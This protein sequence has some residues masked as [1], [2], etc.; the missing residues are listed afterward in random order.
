MTEI[1]TDEACRA[2]IERGINRSLN[3]VIG[4]WIPFAGEPSLREVLEHA[5]GWL[6][7]ITRLEERFRF[8][9]ERW[10][11]ENSR[12][13]KQY[14]KELADRTRLQSEI[15]QLQ[16]ELAQALNIRGLVS[17]VGLSKEMYKYLEELAS[18]YPGKVI[19]APPEALEFPTQSINRLLD[20]FQAM[21]HYMT[22]HHISDAHRSIK[23]GQ[24]W[25]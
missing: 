15:N 2:Q 11:D 6:S 5:L 12:L 9:R 20:H 3:S 22:T 18:T 10:M 7:T 8:H 25:H 21:H 24:E 13:Q 17:A 16:S 4:G 23:I 1:F 19:A 14:N